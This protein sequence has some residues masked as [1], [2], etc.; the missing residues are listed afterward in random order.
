MS[1]ESEISA[2]EQNLAEARQAVEDAFSLRTT[3][4]EPEPIF[5]KKKEEDN[6]F[7]KGDDELRRAAAELQQQRYEVGRKDGAHIANDLPIVER[8][9][10]DPQTGRPFAPHRT[11]SAEEA[12]S[13]LTAKRSEELQQN[14]EAAYDDLVREVSQFRQEPVDP[15]PQLTP[16]EEQLK[17]Q[18][19]QQ[20][21]RQPALEGSDVPELQPQPEFD[22]Q[23]TPLQ[24]KLQSLDPE[25]RESLEQQARIATTVANHYTEQ[26]RQM[27]QNV[28]AL[29]YHQIPEFNNL[30]NDDQRRAVLHHMAQTDPNRAAQ[31]VNTL[32]QA[33]I[34]LQQPQAVIEQAKQ[35]EA[36]EFARWAEAE[37]KK[38]SAKFKNDSEAHWAFLRS[39][40]MDILTESGMTREQIAHEYNTNRLFRSAA[41]QEVLRLAAEHRLAQRNRPRAAPNVPPVTMR[42]G[43]S[44]DRPTRDN[45]YVT[46]LRN[47]AFESGDPK[48]MARYLS[49]RRSAAVRRS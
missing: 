15:Q 3:N 2:A 49:A 1:T 5:E 13:L 8:E 40:V 42:P 43:A 6:T 18:W 4:P 19:E 16:E 38:Y 35:G 9:V 46:G 7:G 34:I 23:L 33:A 10:L 31:V 25:I 30:V 20:H 27:V 21:P 22:D 44:S 11:L 48:Q 29:A 36:L 14:D 39:E 24:R 26:A 17:Q 37:D 32:R 41:G 47:R 45:S 12:A 28:E